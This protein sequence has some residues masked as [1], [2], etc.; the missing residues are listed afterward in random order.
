MGRK[1][2]VSYKYSDSE[3]YPLQAGVLQEAV[4][5]TTVRNYVDQLQALLDEDH[6]NKGEDDGE[7]MANFA[8]ATIASKLRTKIF[9]SSITIV[10]ISPSMKEMFKPE[11]D[12]WIPWEIS[13]SLKEHT[14]NGITSRTNAVLAIVLPNRSGEYSY[15]LEDRTC[16]AT[17]CKY[18]KT[19]TLFQML[20]VNMFNQK[21]KTTLDCAQGDAIYSGDFS[22]IQ[23]IKWCDFK[24]NMDFYLNKAVEIN[25]KS[26]QYNITKQVA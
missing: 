17:G 26:D 18:W 4:N 20:S 5:P 1:I 7:S 23:A 25:E 3:V 11:S 22:Y 24:N 21:N 8:D 9:D 15:F 12:Q 14:R 16:C 10:L 6:I 2:F 13:Y 19:N